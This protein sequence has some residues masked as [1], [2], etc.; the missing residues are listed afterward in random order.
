MSAF[1]LQGWLSTT[2]VPIFWKHCL[3]IPSFRNIAR[4]LINIAS[5]IQQTLLLDYSLDTNDINHELQP[6]KKR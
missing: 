1:S 3:K 6:T 2:Q 4:N 5:T